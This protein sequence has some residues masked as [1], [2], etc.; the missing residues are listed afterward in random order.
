MLTYYEIEVVLFYRDYQSH[1]K[2]YVQK[3]PTFY[4]NYIAHHVTAEYPCN[5][6]SVSDE[7]V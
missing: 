3:L 7:R 6:V 1:F 5:N 2:N 4:N